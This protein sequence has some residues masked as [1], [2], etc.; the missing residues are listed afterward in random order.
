MRRRSRARELAI[1]FL[2]HLDLR[3]PEALGDLD[4][5]LDAAEAEAREDAKGASA[6]RQAGPS[7]PPKRDMELREFA[8]RLIE[9]TRRHRDDADRIL[10]GV[11]RNWDLKRMAAVDRNILRMA[12]YEMLHC[13]DI[14]PKVTINEAI[15][16]GKR[17]ST[18]NSG[19]FINGILDRIR[20]DL[21]SGAVPARA[22][23]AVDAETTHTADEP[24]A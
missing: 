20:I 3:G 2:Y 13:S 15:E 1:Q 18:G 8:V 14:P 16:L 7:R 5:F 10:A 6:A 22:A 12:I 23:P 19:A 9:G 11:T 4:A 21:E 24:T 17:F